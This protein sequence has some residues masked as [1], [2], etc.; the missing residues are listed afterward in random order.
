MS[1]IAGGMCPFTVAST[2]G[3]NAL[4][5]AETY[6]WAHQPCIERFCKLW[7]VGHDRRG[8]PFEDC[9][10]VLE[11]RGALTSN[12]QI[13]QRFVGEPNLETPRY[14]LFLVNLYQIE[15]NL[16]LDGFVIGEDLFSSLD[17]ALQWAHEEYKKELLEEHRLARAK[18]EEM[19]SRQLAVGKHRAEEEQKWRELRLE[20]IRRALSRK[21]PINEFVLEGRTPLMLAIEIRDT[22]LIRALIAAGARTDQRYVD[23]RGN[24]ISVKELAARHS[25]TL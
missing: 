7:Q 20:H 1:Y 18:E 2:G 21:G 4:R 8:I 24:Y 5:T 22:E 3:T 25:V 9:A 19:L 11:A 10:F 14:R 17:L 16:T 23:E 13:R 6:T 15:K 12:A